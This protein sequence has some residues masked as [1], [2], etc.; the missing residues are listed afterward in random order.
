MKKSLKVYGSSPSLNFF[1]HFKNYTNQ[2][3]FWRKSN[4]FCNVLG[5]PVEVKCN[6]WTYSQWRYISTKCRYLCLQLKIR[7]WKS[8][9]EILLGQCH[10][11]FH[12]EFF[13][14]NQLHLGRNSWV[15]AKILEDLCVSALILQWP[16]FFLHENSTLWLEEYTHEHLKY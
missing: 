11:L 9:K 1:P 15:F 2:V 3:G 7:I 6:I 13:F 5:L 10:E 14:I 12:P 8:F 4:D 16:L